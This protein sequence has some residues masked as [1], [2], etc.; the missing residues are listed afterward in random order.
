MPGFDLVLFQENTGDT[1]ELEKQDFSFFIGLF[2]Q[3]RDRQQIDT[4]VICLAALRAP[5]QT[6]P[7]TNIHI[8]LCDPW[9]CVS[10]RVTENECVCEGK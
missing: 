2:I 10:E 6:Q 9:A 3:S 1:Q 7:G 8:H 5:K 4:L